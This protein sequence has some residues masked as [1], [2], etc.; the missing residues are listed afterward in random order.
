VKRDRDRARDARRSARADAVRAAGRD[1]AQE[2]R[3][4]TTQSGTR[5]LRA[6]RS[7]SVTARS[8]PLHAGARL[9]VVETELAG[10][11]GELVAKTSQTQAVL[12]P[13]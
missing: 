5:F 11:D 4:A 6:V 13:G 10:D 3:T 9:I 1:R 12:P 7:G 8:R 2:H